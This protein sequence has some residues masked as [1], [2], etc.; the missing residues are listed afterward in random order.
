MKW[1]RAARQGRGHERWLRARRRSR[2]Q[3]LV[4][5][6]LIV[7]PF[8]LVFFS[9]IEFALITASVGS[10]DF[11]ARSGARLGSV[12]GRT[13]E[14][15]DQQIITEAM[16]HVS[17]V[18]MAQP[19]EIDIFRANPNG[20]PNLLC[21][22]SV[23]QSNGL[24]LSYNLGDPNCAE[25]VYLPPFLPVT[26]LTCTPCNWPVD[27]RNDTN[28]NADYVGVRIL[29]TYTYV[30]GFLASLGSG[31][32]L[33]TYS[34]QRIEPQD[35]SGHRHS[36]Q[37]DP[38]AATGPPPLAPNLALATPAEVGSPSRRPGMRNIT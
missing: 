14:T 37:P 31:L 26:Q 8:F 18:V 6:S 34:T 38:L 36:T 35:Y 22:G 1:M 3:S 7:L 33:S 25:N 4:E 9:I 12:I 21:F 19:T 16:S 24:P 11:A 20:N 5:F 15:A 2:G 27:N 23:T 32:N 30:T 29:Y 28:L 10:F 17:G 13:S